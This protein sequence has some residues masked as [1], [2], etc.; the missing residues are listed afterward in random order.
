MKWVKA[1]LLEYALW[2]LLTIIG[3][4]SNIKKQVSEPVALQLN[5]ASK[6]MWDNILLAFKD[7]LG[8]AEASYL[9][10][11]KSTFYSFV[12]FYTFT[13]RPPSIL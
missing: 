8:K 11:A 10:K 1:S 12:L 2:N 5:K 4:Q 3:S 13:K 6:D 7:V 9:T